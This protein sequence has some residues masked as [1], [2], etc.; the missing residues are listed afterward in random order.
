MQEPELDIPAVRRGRRSWQKLLEGEGL[1]QLPAAHDALTAKLI[2]RAGFPAYQVGGF[3]LVGARYGRPDVDLE[4]FG[5]KNR[6]V[7][8]VIDGCALPVL[9]DGDDG[10][11]DAK[12]VTRTVRGYEALGA[13]AIFLE[14][15][16]AP[17]R[18]GHMAGKSV[19]PRKDMVAKI[20]AAVSAR[21][22]DDTFIL[23]RTDAIAPEG[24]ES[25]IARAQAY[26]DAGAHGAYVEGPIS[27]QQLER[28]GKALHDAPLATSVLE[29]GGV[30]PWLS[31]ED[32]RQMGFS[33]IL[34]PTSVL[35]QIAR[36]SARA[37]ANLRAGRPLDPD[38][39][40]DMQA[41]E[42]LVD[43]PQWAKIESVFPV[44]QD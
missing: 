10:Y 20:R 42:D 22:N 30:T 4:H 8:D 17:K 38:A 26:L 3:A 41:F 33:M 43:L 6:A 16:T 24:V 44:G 21:Q 5:E 11:G 25:A 29:R 15:Q 37:L 18:C 7:Q 36:A 9:V 23:A 12:N 35:F 14:D 28:V 31:P 40:I 13:S 32:F 39:S 19:I 27:V 1:L 2:E 34:Y